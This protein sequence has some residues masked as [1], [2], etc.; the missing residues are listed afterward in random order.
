MQSQNRLVTEGRE[1][2]RCAGIRQLPRSVRSMEVEAIGHEQDRGRVLPNRF[3]PRCLR[4]RMQ[5][6]DP[7][8][9]LGEASDPVTHFVSIEG[10]IQINEAKPIAV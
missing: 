6:R 4:A 5:K 7:V 1:D 9:V 3:E 8:A 10:G 2:R